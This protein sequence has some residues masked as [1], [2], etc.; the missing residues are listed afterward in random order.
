M[1]GRWAYA[2]CEV[3]RD[4]HP[5][6]QS[7]DRSRPAA[8][9]VRVYSLE[10]RTGAQ[11]FTQRRKAKKKSKAGLGSHQLD[12]IGH[13]ISAVGSRVKV[14]ACE[15]Y[16]LNPVSYFF[17][18]FCVYPSASTS[19][20]GPFTSSQVLSGSSRSTASPWPSNEGGALIPG[21]S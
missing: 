8:H 11:S 20:Q 10:K 19:G 3:R 1:P 6:F 14:E 2:S 15:S 9:A 18:T 12:H 17:C 4:A 16:A 13:S 21:A 7:A 5:M